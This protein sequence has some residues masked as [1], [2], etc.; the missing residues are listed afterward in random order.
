MERYRNSVR[1]VRTDIENGSKALGKHKIGLWRHG[2]NFVKYGASRK[3]NGQASDFGDS[4]NEWNGLI[5]AFGK[6]KEIIIEENSLRILF[7]LDTGENLSGDL[8]KHLSPQ[9]CKS[10]QGTKKTKEALW[11][12]VDRMKRLFRLKKWHSKTLET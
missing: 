11:D 6:V 5:K 12:E 9:K 1:R 4:G 7:A 8:K 10:G 2:Q 3:K